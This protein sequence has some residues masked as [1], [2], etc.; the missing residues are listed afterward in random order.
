[1]ETQNPEEQT[2]DNPASPAEPSLSDTPPAEPAPAQPLNPDDINPLVPAWQLLQEEISPAVAAASAVSAESEEKVPDEPPLYTQSEYDK[3]YRQYQEQKQRADALQDSFFASADVMYEMLAYLNASRLYHGKDAI[4]AS[5]INGI[6]ENNPIL[7]TLAN[8]LRQ[9]S[10]ESGI[11]IVSELPESQ[12]H[13]REHVMNVWRIRMA[14]PGERDRIHAQLFTHRNIP[15][16][17][18]LF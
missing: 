15:D 6:V 14:E 13:L 17:E 7:N 10:I 8:D 11:G 4:M 9:T 16:G 1:M 3:L 5:D 12:E 18:E 2:P